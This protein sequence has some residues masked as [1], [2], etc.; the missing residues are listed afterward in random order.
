MHQLIFALALLLTDAPAAA[1][2]TVADLQWLSGCWKAEGGEA[3]SGEMWSSAEG[4]TMFGISRTVRKGRTVA[5]E[6]LRIAKLDDGSIALIASPSGQ[7]TTRF[8]LKTSTRN[9][10]VFQN[11]GHDFPQRVIYSREGE[12]LTGSIEGTKGGKM[13]RVDFPYLRA[14]CK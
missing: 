3:G 12:R 2:T 1:T 9:R 4:E 11:L 14:T 6:Y 10:A 13:R 5:F 7:D 8:K